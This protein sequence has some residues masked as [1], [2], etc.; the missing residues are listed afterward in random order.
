MR[1]VRLD[2]ELDDLVRRAAAREG[3]SVSEFMRRSAAER[4]QR[5]LPVDEL[6]KDIIG[7]VH[8]GGGVARRTG[9]AFTELLVERERERREQRSRQRRR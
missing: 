1:S 8:T 7:V 5:V 4:A 3:V 9:E 2:A 6:F